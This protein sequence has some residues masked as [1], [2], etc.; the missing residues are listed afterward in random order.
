MLCGTVYSERTP[1]F[2]DLALNDIVVSR[3][4]I[5]AIRFSLY[6]DDQLFSEYSADGLIVSTPTGST[7]YNLSAGGPVAAPEAELM[8]LTPI[9]PHTLNSRSIVLSSESR[10]S[11]RI[12]GREESR[13][14][15][16]FDGES[17]VEL[18]PGDRV[19]IEK[20]KRKTTLIQLQQK[21]FL[22]NIRN[23]MKQI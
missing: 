18:R 7:A 15:V 22:E 5:D 11:I 13:Q 19:E 17:V 4:G 14:A 6:V 2:E 9:C 10:I 8:I 16:S 3:T 23:K 12:E 21:P 1:Q 20:S